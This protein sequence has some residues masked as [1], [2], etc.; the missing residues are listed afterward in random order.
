[1]RRTSLRLRRYSQKITQQPSLAQDWLASLW[2]KDFDCDK[3]WQLFIPLG[4][5]IPDI[6]NHYKNV[7]VILNDAPNTYKKVSY[8]KKKGY[9]VFTVEPFDETSYNQTKLSV[10]GLS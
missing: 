5:F 6:T 8:Y 1:M 3:D 9:I 2:S 7:I 4:S 10:L